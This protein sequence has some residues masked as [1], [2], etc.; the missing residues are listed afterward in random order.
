LA[1]EAE[2]NIELTVFDVL[3]QA[4]YTDNY[5]FYSGKL[6]T[7]IELQNIAPGTYMIKLAVRDR[8]SYQKIVVY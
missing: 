8:A 6:N 2:E 1:G 3:G 5:D 7:Q 4:I